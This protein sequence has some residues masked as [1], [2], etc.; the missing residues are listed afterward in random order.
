M[1]EDTYKY[2]TKSVNIHALY[3]PFLENSKKNIRMF[4]KIV[5]PWQRVTPAA[6]PGILNTSW[7]LQPS[8]WE[9]IVIKSDNLK[10]KK[11][12]CCLQV[13]W[14]TS[15]IWE[16]VLPIQTPT[17]VYSFEPCLALGFKVRT[18]L[19]T[20]EPILKCMCHL[21]ECQLIL[22]VDDQLPL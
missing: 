16:W 17:F 4:G 19:D 12:R 8:S 20:K 14:T 15:W 11:Q 18:H 7:D 22:K 13:S 5:V 1:F 2:M 3:E 6:L 10:K 21:T 9:N